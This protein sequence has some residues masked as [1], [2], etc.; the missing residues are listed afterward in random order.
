M[1][2]TRFVLENAMADGSSTPQTESYILNWPRLMSSINRKSY[3]NVDSR[4]NAQNY[5]IGMKVFATNCV[6][7]T[8]VAPN[9]YYTKR[10][11]KAWHDA[12]KLM[13]KRA[14][15][16][17]KSLGPYGRNLRPYLNV[18][19][20]N[21]TIA[22]LDTESS[23]GLFILPNF[24]G[25]EWTYSKAIVTVPVEEANLTQASYYQQ[26]VLDSY[27]FT[28]LDGSVTEATTA[29]S[30]DDLSSNMTDQDSYISVGMIDEW[31][32]SFHKRS[33]GSGAD[34]I[35]DADNALLQ[36][37]SDSASSEEVLELAEDIQSEGRPWDKD[38]SAYSVG[39]T[40]GYCI[41]VA[42][43]SSYDSFVAPCGLMRVDWIN[44]AAADT[45]RIVFDII[46]I[47]D[48]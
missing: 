47:S 37:T 43:E 21:A 31:L 33:Y 32:D 38:S 25:A 29:E 34:I 11:I 3:D 17:M 2:H 30:P 8:T 24:Q 44:S 35:I 42:G 1:T 45:T 46:D 27:T 18:D 7:H 20:E 40:G 10:A 13:F 41:S 22:E 28:I 4:G 23:A 15:V 16:S 36:L 48:M 6:V 12:R 5:L 14:G 26:D 9:T 39:V 19:H